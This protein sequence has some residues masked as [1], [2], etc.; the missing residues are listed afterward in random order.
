ML[1]LK[2]FTFASET[3][4]L[5]FC[6]SASRLD[7]TCYDQGNAYPFHI[8]PHKRFN[9]LEFE[10]ITIIYGGNGSGKSTVLNIISEKLKLSRMAPFNNAVCMNDYLSFCRYELYGTLRCVPKTSEII[11]SDGVFDLLLD[12]RAINEEVDRRREKLFSEYD[13]LKAD[14]RDNGWQMRSLSEYEEL[15]RRSEVTRLTKSRYTSKRL[16]VRET[17]IKSNGES[18]FLYFTEKVRE[19]SLYLLDEP[20][21][22]LSAALQS[23]L[24]KFLFEAVRFYNCQLI[25]S[26]HSPFL[27]SM[28]GAKIYDLDSTPV[29]V[30]SWT[31]LENVR[32]YYELFTSHSHEFC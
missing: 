31:D 27:L 3:Q 25:I 15:K 19:N 26:T 4:E 32:A 9:R 10:P 20:E 16:P 22:S 28:P 23:E 29:C 8:F 24:A 6:M 18:A 2:S 12:V 13:E 17:R 14:C 30:R 1:Y 21:N 5:D 11:T 7:M